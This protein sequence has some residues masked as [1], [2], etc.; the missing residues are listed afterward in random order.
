[1]DLLPELWPC[2]FSFVDFSTKVSLRLTCKQFEEVLQRGITNYDKFYIEQCLE[3]NNFQLFLLAREWQ[4]PIVPKCWDAAIKGNCIAF[5]KYAD[6]HNVKIYSILPCI[7]YNNEDSFLRHIDNHQLPTEAFAIPCKWLSK[8]H[9]VD[10]SRNMPYFIE[11]AIQYNNLEL[12]K[13]LLKGFAYPPYRPSTIIEAYK[14][15]K[16]DMVLYLLEKYP[17]QSI[18]YRNLI[19]KMDHLPLFK[20]IIHTKECL[21]LAIVYKSTNILN[22]ILREYYQYSSCFLEETPLQIIETLFANGI[23]FQISKDGV[24]VVIYTCNTDLL[25][26]IA[27]GDLWKGEIDPKELTFNEK[28][29]KGITKRTLDSILKLY[30]EF[31]RDR[32]DAFFCDGNMEAF[33][34]FVMGNYIDSSEIV[35]KAARIGI[36]AF[37][38]IEEKNIEIKEFVIEDL[39]YYANLETIEYIAEKYPNVLQEVQDIDPIIHCFHKIKWLCENGLLNETN[40]DFFLECHQVTGLK[41]WIDTSTID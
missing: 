28:Y 4:Q 1:M 6:E 27:D 33:E 20:Q 41:E 2:I 3:D 11:K 23:T 7:L 32:N 9:K 5:E 19:V 14:D 16:Y 31:F 15:E 29:T 26:F 10:Y 22:Y 24:I 8:Y 40:L 21:F 18:S 25:Q 37:Q 35:Y 36:P 12:L 39:M 17:L 13:E 38:F 30:P 34:W